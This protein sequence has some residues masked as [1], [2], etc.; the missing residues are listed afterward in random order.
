MKGFAAILLVTLFTTTAFAK[1]PTNTS[2]AREVD[3]YLAKPETLRAFWDS[4]LRLESNDGN[5]KLKIGGRLMYDNI[6]RSSDEF[7]T[8]V[9]A[10]TSFFR[11]VRFYMAGTIYKNF[12]FKV[13]VDFSKSTLALQDVWGSIKVK[14]LGGATVKVGHHNEPFSLQQLTSSKYIQLV[15]RSVIMMFVPG[16]NGGISASHTF[17]EQRVT[18][19]LGWFRTTDDQGRAMVDGDSGVSFRVTGLVIQRQEDHVLLHFG[20]SFTYRSV[21]SVQYRGRPGVGDKDRPF[22]T[23]EIIA[24]HTTVLGFEIAFRWRSITV[25]GEYI[26]ADVDAVA[27]GDPSFGGFYIEIGWFVTGEVRKYSVDEGVWGRTR[28]KHD[29]DDGFGALQIV[30]RFETVDLNNA[31]ITGGEGDVVMLGANWHLNPNV[32]IMFDVVF[33]DVTS[34]PEGA[35]DLVAFVIRFQIDF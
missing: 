10:D 16:R 5:F 17:M 6:W 30:C 13:E 9:T 8:N 1:K 21:M 4:G 23:G 29:S 20:F 27:S 15:E 24:E 31:S 7:A 3:Q 32:R 26:M 18:A 25:Q 11:R 33:A 19:A 34:G 35:G 2:L 14:W 12:G 22:D 28:P